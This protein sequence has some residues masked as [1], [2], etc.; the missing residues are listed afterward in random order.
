[1]ISAQDL[2]MTIAKAE[3]LFPRVQSLYQQLPETRCA[4]DQPGACCTFLPEMTAVEALQWI[5]L[6]QQMPDEVL[7]ST[8]KKFVEFYFTSLARSSH[9]PFLMEGA[10][11]IYEYRTFACRAYGLWSG[12]LGRKRTQQSRQEK[13]TLRRTWKQFGVDLPVHVV[14]FEQDYC[15]KVTPSS[16]DRMSDSAMLD[17]FRE[18]YDLDQ[19]VGSLQERFEQEYHSDFSFL[20]TSLVLGMK[21]ALID[22]L[23]VTKELVQ[24]GTEVRLR[25]VL[26]LVSPEKLRL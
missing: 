18:I 19:E 5:R 11:S 14:E 2:I 21:K 6:L 15:D 24:E 17:L 23:A 4:C 9:C 7:L 25:R 22:K 26:D 3:R 20:L 16:D 12:K 1:M 13:K 8:L 10:C